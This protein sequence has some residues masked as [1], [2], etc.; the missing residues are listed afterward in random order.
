ME[1]LDT[2]DGIGQCTK[3]GTDDFNA[4]FSEASVVAFYGFSFVQPLWVN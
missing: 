1:I 4:G 2:M 3:L